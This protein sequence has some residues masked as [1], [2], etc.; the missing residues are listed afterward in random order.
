MQKTKQNRKRKLKI[1]QKLKLQMFRCM[2]VQNNKKMLA[3]G[4][5]LRFNASI[6]FADVIQW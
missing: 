2:K 4:V 3:N 1:Q 5:V 6:A